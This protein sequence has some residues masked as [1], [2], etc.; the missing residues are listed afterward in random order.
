M[1]KIWMM[2]LLIEVALNSGIKPKFLMKTTRYGYCSLDL[3]LATF[4]ED[5]E[6]DHGIN[7]DDDLAKSLRQ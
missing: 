5:E 1:T 4:D 7:S 3:K 6:R 2:M